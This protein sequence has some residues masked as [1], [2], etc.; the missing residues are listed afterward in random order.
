MEEQHEEG[1]KEEIELNLNEQNE[2][3]GESNFEGCS[4]E[5]GIV[6]QPENPF[7]TRGR[8][9][10]VRTGGAKRPRNVIKNFI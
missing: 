1:I 9:R 8:P 3:S 4:S 5:S 2:S 6:Q 7:R 10:I